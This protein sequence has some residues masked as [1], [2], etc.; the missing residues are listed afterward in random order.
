MTKGLQASRPWMLGPRMVPG[1]SLPP[2]S[3]HSR[4]HPEPDLQAAGQR[5][6][7]GGRRGRPR[8]P[9]PQGRDLQGLRHCEQPQ[10]E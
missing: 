5:Q 7:P 2:V 6:W 9:A 3:F 10:Q 1:D 4:G 8:R